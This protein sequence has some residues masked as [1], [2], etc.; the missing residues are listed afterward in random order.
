MTK[1]KYVVF[2]LLA[3]RTQKISKHHLEVKKKNMETTSIVP[4]RMSFLNH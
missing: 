2:A 1:G 3:F 4:Y